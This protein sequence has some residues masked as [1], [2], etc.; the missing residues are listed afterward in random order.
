MDA[1]DP[2]SR[3]ITKLEIWQLGDS[4]F[5][6]SLDQQ[7]S[8]S[9]SNLVC[10][11]QCYERPLVSC[12]SVTLTWIM[13]KS[14]LNWS[15]EHFFFP[16]KWEVCPVSLTRPC[17]SV[18]HY[19]DRRKKMA[20]CMAFARSQPR[21]GE[22]LEAWIRMTSRSSFDRELLGA[23]LAWT[24]RLKDGQ[25]LELPGRARFLFARIRLKFTT[26]LFWRR[27]RNEL[28]RNSSVVFWDRRSYLLWSCVL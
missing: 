21:R 9:L 7:S 12:C 15:Q 8:S 4:F 16:V 27:A 3:R 25:I 24:V 19:G 10:C 20:S 26:G 17:E 28:S 2:W 13:V 1:Y 22:L 5:S 18:S 23:I 6:Y 11:Y 14:S